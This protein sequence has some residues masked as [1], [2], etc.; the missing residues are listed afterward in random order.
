MPKNNLF[1]KGQA[2]T[3][4]GNVTFIE[5]MFPGS[6]FTSCLNITS[7][8]CY[9]YMSFVSLQILKRQCLCY[10]PWSHNYLMIVMVMKA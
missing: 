3:F 5:V 1:K 7:V 8:V 4:W 9:K 10:K 2:K 6:D